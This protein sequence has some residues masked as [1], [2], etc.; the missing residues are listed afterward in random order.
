MNLVYPLNAVVSLVVGIGLWTLW[1]RDKQHV[2]LRSMALGMLTHPLVALSFGLLDTPFASSSVAAVLVFST[3]LAMSTGFAV[4]AVVEFGGG[5]M[6]WPRRALL[7]SLL[8]G[9]TTVLIK[10]GQSALIGWPQMAAYAAIG[11]AFG[12]RRWQHGNTERV[13]A[14]TF[15]LLG[16]NWM[17][18]ALMGP[19]GA[20]YQAAVGSVLT[21]AVTKPS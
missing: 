8:A 10:S 11:L 1:H 15:V 17:L 4:G 5:Q 19:E 16:A 12:V 21:V 18:V 13:I 7:V 3:A 14:I 20:L 6:T 2:F 9:S